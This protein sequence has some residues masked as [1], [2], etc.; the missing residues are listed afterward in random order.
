MSEFDLYL[1]NT[2]TI[3]PSYDDPF[4]DVAV[5]LYGRTPGGEPKVVTATGFDPYFYIQADEADELPVG[6][7]SDLE[8]YEETDII[9]LEDR[10]AHITP[11]AEPRELVKVVASHPGAVP[12][13]RE[14]WD[15]TW[16]A[17]VLFHNR[18]RIDKDIRSG[19]TVEFDGDPDEDHLVV[20]HT[21][22]TPC[23]IT[24]VEPRYCVFDIETD[25]RDVGFPEPGDARI[26]SIAAY[27][28]YDDEY[29]A[30]LDLDD[31][32][33]ESKFDLTETHQEL[34]G[35]DLLSLADLGIEGVDAL[36]F[37]PDER[38]MLIAF[39][40][41]ISDRN[42]D[43]ICGWNSGDS[44]SD[45]FDLPHLIERMREV[46][47]SPAR[48]SREGEVSCDQYGDDW[49]VE[50]TGRTTY[51]LM[52]AW[53]S[54][55]FTEPD[56]KKLDRVAADKLDDTK[57]E[58]PGM[59]YFEMYDSAP[60]KFLNYN[61]KD[62][63][64]TVEIAAAEGVFAFKQRLK[65]MVGADWEEVRE[66]H[67]FVSMSVRRKCREHG[68]SMVTARDN[69][70]VREA[71]GK[72]DDEVNYEGAYVFDAFAGVKENVVGVDLASLYPMTQWMLN[73]SPD[74]KIDR[75]VAW[76]HDVEHVVAANGVAFRTDVDSIIRELVDEYD[77]IKMEYKRQRNAAEP[78]S[79]ERARLVLLYNV[80]KTIYNSYYG[81]TGWDKSPIYDPE[82]AAAV[83]L[84]GQRVIKR[85]AEWLAEHTRGEI[86]Y[87][88][89]DSNYV[90][91]PS[92]WSQER[93]L[94]EAADACV[95]LTQRIYPDLCNEFLI[96]PTDNRWE[97]ELEM[98]AERMFQAD[99]KKRYAYLK[100]WDEG[101]PFDETIND[102]E[103]KVDIT[104]FE[105]K[106]SDIAGV[107]KEVQ[108]DVLTQIVRG[109]SKQD[110][111]DRMFE[112]ARSID[113]ADPDWE[114]LGIPG[115]LGKKIPDTSSE[116]RKDDRYAWSK[117]RDTPQSAHPRGAWFA[118]RLLHVEFEKGD[119]PKRAYTK[120]TATC[121]GEPVDVICYEYE[122][123]LEA[124]TVD[125]KMDVVK[126]QEKV[127]TGPMRPILEALDLE[128]DEAIRGD[129]VE[130]A[131]LG[132]FM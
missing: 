71:A 48:L 115:G 39:A 88:D 92:D 43:L 109:A 41:W 97:I 26:L 34:L 59:G 40:S 70:R 51:D 74:T 8:R 110:V 106:R 130:Q 122:H 96:D 131:G 57:I 27:D 87:G 20:D 35:Q 129:A 10:F 91:F 7:H 65:D 77:E 117:S 56:S 112:A 46:G 105:Y 1:T 52:D 124:A 23:E 58:H 78:G 63:H 90:E 28:S 123:D 120:K 101:M 17:D 84:T 32:S 128:P 9:P 19:V 113:A 50:I 72:D 111:A 104:G 45:G 11:G 14:F 64:L 127:L 80:A 81:Y 60:V 3:Y 6:D 67:D 118:N 36:N 100:V 4:G 49:Y 2:E 53:A 89:T 25:D 18:F 62:T 69:P 83:T 73:A 13:L 75:K 116:A 37:E 21:Q 126:M 103:G 22:I 68:L 98:L 54:T 16:G 76:K 47:A 93:T 30:F 33:I 61:A 38:R 82:I 95:E 44:N 86:V 66:N 24:D 29:T 55:K 85:T 114:R 79:E 119:K 42:P 12:K 94:E 108:R 107:T 121:E 132:G 31:E 99:K 125:L 5:R 15:T 102:G